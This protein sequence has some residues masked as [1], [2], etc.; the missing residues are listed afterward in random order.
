MRQDNS[1]ERSRRTVLTFMPIEHEL[2]APRTL[3]RR[4]EFERIVQRMR[5]SAFE[6][7]DEGSYPIEIK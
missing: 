4:Q 6:R 2:A 7:Q 3:D 5:K 1:Q